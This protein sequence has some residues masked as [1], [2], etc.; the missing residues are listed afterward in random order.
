M[1]RKTARPTS[2]PGADR[3]RGWLLTITLRDVQPPI[4]RRIRV[5]DITLDAFH[6]AIQAAMGWQ[7]KHRHYFRIG[8]AWYGRPGRLDDQPFAAELRDSARQSLG[9]ILGGA[10]PPDR[11]LYVYDMGDRWEHEILPGGATDAV[12][13]TAACLDGFRACPPEDCGGVGGYEYLL[14]VLG[15]PDHS[16]HLDLVESLGSYDPESFDPAW[17][18]ARMTRLLRAS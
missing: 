18:T 10:D 5:G 13:P 17:A 11:F 8:D 15:D 14:Q 12:G 4:M 2:D 1:P 3:A 9:A 6:A 7:D 16:E